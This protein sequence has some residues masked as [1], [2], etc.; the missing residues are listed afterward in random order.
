MVQQRSLLGNL[1]LLRAVAKLIGDLSVRSTIRRPLQIQHTPEFIDSA[2]ASK[3]K[4]NSICF[5][6]CTLCRQNSG[7]AQRCVPYWLGS[8]AKEAHQE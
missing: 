4:S 8:V 7:K 1:K 6:R 3:C 5:D 2:S